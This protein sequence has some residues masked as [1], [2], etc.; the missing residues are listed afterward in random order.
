MLQVIIVRLT[1]LTTSPSVP[2]PY[3]PPSK[4]PEETDPFGD[5][6]HTLLYLALLIAI[7]PGQAY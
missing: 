5:F 4:P 1:V 7:T 2:A 3:A 6:V